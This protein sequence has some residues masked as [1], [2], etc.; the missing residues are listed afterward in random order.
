MMLIRLSWKNIW[1]NKA[2]SA[3]VITAFALGIF[4]G[5]FCIAFMNGM[6]EQ[7]IHAITAIEI[8]HIQIHKPGFRDN[9]DFSLR[10]QNT[11]SLLDEIREHPDVQGASKRIVAS[12]MLA[13][14]ESV[15]GARVM[16]IE[17]AHE[18]K[19][20]EL[21]SRISEGSYFETGSRYPV[22]IGKRMAEKLKVTLKNKVIITVQDTA[23]HV[24]SGA[25]RVAGI[26]ATD[27]FGFDEST[28]F[29]LYDDLA[30]LTSIPLH[31]AHEIAIMMGNA[32]D[33][34]PMVEQIDKSHP[35]LEVL[36]WLKL[37]PEASSLAGMMDQYMVIFLIII[38]LA[39]CFGIIN[40]MLMAVMERTREL[41]MLM[42]VGMSRRRV[43]FMIVF[44][45]TILALTGGLLGMLAGWGITEY[46]GLTGINLSMWSDAFADFG[47]S[48]IIYPVISTSS[49]IETAVLLILTGFI[50]SLYPA[51]RAWK[52]SP[53]EAIRTD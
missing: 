20:S 24:A 16:G 51:Y 31:Q 39:L 4:A 1:R 21:Y 46:Y 45:T 12:G 38:L 13:T 9:N 41:G 44:E 3:V 34:L 22:V 7:R 27:N 50:A 52:L 48:S 30:G 32:G 14:A 2:R 17:P 37:S 33:V 5:V 49:L 43:F 8:S 47:Y 42:A 29:V 26:F 15:T 25:F 36:D 28:V 40:T 53:C 6:V 11:G 23:G 35:E 18:R 10:I 19:V